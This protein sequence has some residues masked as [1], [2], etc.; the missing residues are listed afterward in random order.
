MSHGVHGAQLQSRLL[1]P[2]LISVLQTPGVVVCRGGVNLDPREE[3]LRSQRLSR[4]PHSA[5]LLAAAVLL[6][7]A[8]TAACDSAADT[9]PGVF[10]GA[11]GD[12]APTSSYPVDRSWIQDFAGPT[13]TAPDPSLLAPY[14]SDNGNGN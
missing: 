14:P 2:S 3:T 4:V 10:P 8:V 12:S 6:L 5:R 13:G 1:F 9:A 11:T 7:A